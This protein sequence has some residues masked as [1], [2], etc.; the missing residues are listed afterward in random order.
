MNVLFFLVCHIIGIV[1][2]AGATVVDFFCYGRFWK[3]Y[4]V[5]RRGGLA[6]MNVLSVFRF[7]FV[8]GFLLLL[9]SGL[10]MVAL[11]HGLFA[12]QRWFRIKMGIVVLVLVNGIVFGRRL[13]M[14]IRKLVEMDIAES[15]LAG[16]ASQSRKSAAGDVQE[17]LV[18]LKS[19]LRVFHVLQMLLFLVIFILSVYKF[20]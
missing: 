19:R 14:K 2:M 6:V 13:V 10:C 18:R 8:F 3:Q 12:E 20:N 4:A 11:S 16:S 7:L 17:A 15:Q 9:V 5:D 1:T